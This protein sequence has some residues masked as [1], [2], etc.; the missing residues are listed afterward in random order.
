MVEMSLDIAFFFYLF[1]NGSNWSGK[2]SQKKKK[3]TPM[4]DSSQ[5]SISPSLRS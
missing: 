5:P 4:L 1:L 3:K 2:G